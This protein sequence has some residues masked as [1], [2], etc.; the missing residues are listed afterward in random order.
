MVLFVFVVEE[1]WEGFLFVVDCVGVG[2]GFLLLF[3]FLLFLIVNVLF[4]GILG[5]V[6][7]C[8]GVVVGLWVLLIELWIDFLLR[9]LSGILEFLCFLFCFLIF[10]WLDLRVKVCRFLI[11][12]WL[13]RIV[14]NKW[15][16]LWYLCFIIELMVLSRVNSRVWFVLFVNRN[17]GDDMD[18][19]SCR[20][21]E[22]VVMFRFLSCGVILLMMVRSVG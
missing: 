13:L 2:I 9:E 19:N 1:V 17:E 15:G 11:F 6:W 5:N 10:F 22:F 18:V 7:F 4:F 20:S 3:L 14:I 12:F 21:L 8:V 16:F